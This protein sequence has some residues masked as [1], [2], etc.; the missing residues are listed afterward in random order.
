MLDVRRLRVLREVA[1]RGSIAAAAEAL[2][3]TPSAVSQQLQKLERETGVQ[4]LRRGPS[5]VTLTEA[6]KVLVEHT[7]SILDGLAH[8]EADLRRFAG[9][10]EPLRLGSITTAAVTILPEALKR[11]EGLRPGAE[12]RVVEADPLASLADLRAR[13][14]DLAVVFEYD[15]VPLPAD[16]RIELETLLQEP[17]RIVLPAGHPAARKR[18]V[19]VEELAKEA[20]IKPT[21]RSSCQEFTARA[22]RAAGFEP[23]IVA[24]FDDY[25]AMQ[26]AV[27]AGVGVA[28]APDLGLTRLAPGLDVR[29][30]AFAPPQRRIL[31]AIRRGDGGDPAIG[32]MLEALRGA[33][34]A[35]EPLFPVAAGVS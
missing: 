3:F 7:D 32:A 26:N 35:R 25:A 34:A 1:I 28:F 14:L 5:S 23:R 19:R 16:D 17:M 6:G 22:C 9:L 10:E 18:A 13:E 2:S 31:A 33:V 15:H 30:I 11:Y 29:P 8:A 12:V 21:S 4:L 27:A 24:E 20:W